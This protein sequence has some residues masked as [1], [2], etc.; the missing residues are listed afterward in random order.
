MPSRTIAGIDIGT[1]KIVT[2][3]AEM[4]SDN[5]LRILGHGIVPSKGVERGLIVNIE[6]AA[7]A[8]GNSITMA[9]QMGGYRIGSAYVSISGRHI[10]TLSRI[11]SAAVSRESMV[12]NEHIHRAVENAQAFRMGTGKELLHVMPYRYVIDDLEVNDPCGMHGVRLDVHVHMVLC[13]TGAIQNLLKVVTQNGVEVEDI[14][15]QQLATAEAVLTESDRENGVLLVDIG[16]SNTGVAFVA[17]QRTTHTHIIPVGGNTVTNDISFTFQINPHS[18]EYNKKHIGEAIADASRHTDIIEIEGRRP[19]DVERVARF[20]FNDC[21]QARLDELIQF[22]IYEVEYSNY[23]GAYAAGIVLSG[24]GALM[25]RIDDLFVERFNAPVRIGEPMDVR[26]HID[27][28]ISTQ[29]ATA[30]GLVRW[31]FTHGDADGGRTN[32]EG[33]W[34]E[35]YERMK[36]WFREFL[37]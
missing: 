34:V 3:I 22:I 20:E 23:D 7:R 26:G 13:D 28:L 8:V 18:A 15:L 37:P 11:G 5:V 17:Q 29:F 6:E 4:D 25:E 33:T 36:Q 24:G 32:E 35:F 2:V 10:E 12:T 27:G 30:I 19:G 1:T 9:E 21:I 31:G 16:C 14:V